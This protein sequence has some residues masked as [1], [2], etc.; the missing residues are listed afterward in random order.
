MSRDGWLPPGV[1]D[2]D[3]DD[4]IAPF[5]PFEPFEPPEEGYDVVVFLDNGSHGE[6][7]RAVPAAEAFEAF[8]HHCTSAGARIGIVD[9]VIITDAD[10]CT[11]VEWLRGEGVTYPIALARR[12]NAL[13][14]AR[15][16][17][18]RCATTTT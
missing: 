7:R 6:E 15:R 4:A 18:E 16:R 9:R 17:G 3:I 2:K 5:E 13:I 14:N 11:C 1:T 12:L 10:G 8:L